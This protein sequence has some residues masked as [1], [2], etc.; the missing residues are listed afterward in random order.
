MYTRSTFVGCTNEL[1]TYLSVVWEP[2]VVCYGS[3]YKGETPLFLHV[4]TFNIAEITRYKDIELRVPDNADSV[5]L[6]PKEW[7][8]L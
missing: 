3:S 6:G 2:L 1:N 5:H 4:R 8:D 7:K